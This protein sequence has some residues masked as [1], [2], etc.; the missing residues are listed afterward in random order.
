[1]A[2]TKSR[3]KEEE[4]MSRPTGELNALLGKG[5]E[6]EGK[7][8]FEGTVRIDGK[9]KGE[10]HTT[11]TLVIGE[12]ARVDAEISCGTLIVHGE[13]NGNSKA[14]AAVELHSP[15]R[16]KGNIMTPSL[17]IDRGVV[18]EGNCKMENLDSAT[19]TPI[20]KGAAQGGKK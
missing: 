14:K 15:A 12:G 2:F 19:V 20:E 9:F 11:D 8:T 5:S 4:P 6:F 1:M 13:V 17:V 7:L 3:E 10:I 16:V 18:F